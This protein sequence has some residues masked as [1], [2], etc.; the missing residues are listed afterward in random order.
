M[1]MAACA[2]LA[3]CGGDKKVTVGEARPE[4]R[5]VGIT[6]KPRQAVRPAQWPNACDLVSG[7]EIKAI[8]PQGEPGR[9]WSQRVIVSPS[10]SVGP[11]GTGLA[12]N[13]QCA[14]T[15]EL[16]HRTGKAMYRIN[17]LTIRI[18][19]VGDPALVAKL[20]ARTEK[21]AQSPQEDSGLDVP[22][23]DACFVHG[24]S[25][26]EPRGVV[27]RRGPLMFTI[28]TGSWNVDTVVTQTR[29]IPAVIQTVA[30]KV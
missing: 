18:E 21:R 14:Y 1:V 27:C 5:K 12:A 17:N 24:T 16:S 3:A 25:R 13:G 9:P 28:G 26:T 23:T 22:G 2:A 20:F 11:G 30:A 10:D 15:I 7:K 4:A 6:W 19:G 8:L 29:I